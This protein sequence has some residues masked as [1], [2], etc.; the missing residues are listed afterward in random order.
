MTQCDYHNS[1]S[2]GEEAGEHATHINT[3]LHRCASP[4]SPTDTAAATAGGGAK[5][6]LKLVIPTSP[7][8]PCAP[9]PPPPPED[10][11]PPS[12]PPPGGLLASPLGGLAP[13]RATAAVALCPATDAVATG[14]G[15]SDYEATGGD[16]S[17]NVWET[18]N[19]TTAK[20]IRNIGVDEEGGGG[21][22]NRFHDPAAEAEEKFWMEVNTLGGRLLPC[23]DG[24]CANVQ[25]QWSDGGESVGIWGDPSP[26]KRWPKPY[27][28][29]ETSPMRGRNR[30]AWWKRR[31]DAFF[32]AANYGQDV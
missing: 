1:T 18:G 12:P 2:A 16:E 17:E 24:S 28:G 29:R 4:A 26:K 11:A 22:E 10:L 21:G 27:Y 8:S 15:L 3:V 19:Y 6:P 23:G 7:Q 30:R 25:I 9:P 32:E 14:W 5:D 13:N 31:R 20:K